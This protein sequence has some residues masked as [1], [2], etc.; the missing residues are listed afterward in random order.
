MSK[1]IV[2]LM[3][4]FFRQTVFSLAGLLYIMLAM[5]FYLIFFDPRQRTPDFDYYVLVFGLFGL[6]LV[7]LVT[8]TVSARANR[9]VHFPFL[10]RLPSR[11]EYLTAVLLASL[12]FTA[13][14][15]GF[16]AIVALSV[17]GPELTLARAL[18]VPP[19][20][21]AGNIVFGCLALHATDLV[22]SGWSRVY[23]FAILGFLLY[24]Q[25]LVSPLATWL[26]RALGNLG[27]TFLERGWTGLS[28]A[29]FEAGDWFATTGAELLEQA[30]GFVFW[31]FEA[32]GTAVKVGHF[33]WAQAL[34]PAVLL[35]YATFLFLLAADFFSTKDLFLT[36]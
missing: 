34:A 6:V 2:S 27:S 21:I 1:R 18:L 33:G 30:A 17:G 22:A 5:A 24:F 19:L 7:F 15:Q 8:L 36:E 11:P 20:W 29:L 12:A 26:S 28:A 14:V 35:L 25:R 23:V 13:M 9:A 3:L 10:V 4:Y 16:F 31:P 32:I